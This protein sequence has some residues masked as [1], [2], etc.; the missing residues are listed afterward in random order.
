MRMCTTCPAATPMKLQL[1][2]RS[3]ADVNMEHAAP[4]LHLKRGMIAR[5]IR[6]TS[7]PVPAAS[8]SASSA[9]TSCL[10][11]ALIPK[12]NAYNSAA[13]VFGAVLGT[14]AAPPVWREQHPHWC[15]AAASNAV[16]QRAARQH[17]KAVCIPASAVPLQ[18]LE[19]SPA[20]TAAQPSQTVPKALFPR[21]VRRVACTP[22]SAACQRSTASKAP[23]RRLLA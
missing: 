21:P 22:P 5:M 8:K 15:H 16:L 7:G 3:A 19:P 11:L 2:K 4:S 17:V 9:A 6:S 13:A 18:L 10:R 20:P 14:H 1:Q 23:H 12:A